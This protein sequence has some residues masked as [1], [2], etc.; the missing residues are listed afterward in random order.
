MGL[1]IAHIIGGLSVG[2]AERHLVNLLNA[3]S[4]EFRAAIFIGPKSAGPSFHHELDPAV[5]QNFVRIRRRNLPLG[6]VKLASLLKKKKVNVVHCHMFESNL[7]GAIAAR[8]ANVPVVLTSEHGEN[9]WKRLFHRW[10]E[11]RLIS[12]LADLRFCVSPQILALRRDSD[13]VPA[14]KLR[15]IVNG[16]PL[17]ALGARRSSNPVLLIGAVGRFI[18][19]KDYPNLLHAFAELRRREYRTELCILGDGPEMDNV[20]RV[21]D[22]LQLDDIVNLPGLV[23]DVGQWLERFDIYVSSSI[24]EGQ[25]VA[26][27]EAMAHGLPIVATDVGASA[28]TVRHGEGGLIVPPGD[29][30]ALAAALAQLLDDGDLRRTFGRRARQRVESKYS[31]ESV[32]ELHLDTYRNI[33]SLKMARQV[34]PRS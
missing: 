34:E 10:L 33:L 16:T 26:L 25:P 9:P 29:S 19:V 32:A 28:A 30:N 22:E 3:M 27:L 4:C 23:T 11:R 20:K 12:P 31:V 15:L 21:V 1:R 7:Y 13:R 14:S 24:R 17:P 5:E 18:A 2:G 8:L 6:I